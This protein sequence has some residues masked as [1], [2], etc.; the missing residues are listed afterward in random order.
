MKNSKIKPVFFGGK[1]WCSL[2]GHQFI[3]TRAITNHFKEFKCC[4]CHLE[5]TNDEK[6][7]KI[8]LTPEHRDIN[9]TLVH[10]YQK[11]HH[12]V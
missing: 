3:T 11:R 10:F 2:F 5:L 9:E 7:Q 1:V 8:S 6:G 12:L 4:N